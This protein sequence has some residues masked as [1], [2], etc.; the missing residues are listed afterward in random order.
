MIPV[1]DVRSITRGETLEG[2]GVAPTVE[3]KRP[4]LPYREGRD[5]ILRE[6]LEQARKLARANAAVPF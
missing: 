3:V 2:K 6:G 5:P 1:Q 4:P